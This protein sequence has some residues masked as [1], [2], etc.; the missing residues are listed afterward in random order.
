MEQAH[1]SH[2]PAR[3]LRLSRKVATVTAQSQILK[4]TKDQD[5]GIFD[6]RWRWKKPFAPVEE[7]GDNDVPDSD[8]QDKER[9]GRREGVEEILVKDLD[10]NARSKPIH[11]GTALKTSNPFEIEGNDISRMSGNS[12]DAK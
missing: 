11:S 4:I 8:L 2:E 1:G 12:K 9:S 3:H 7:S 10:P 5:N 6:N